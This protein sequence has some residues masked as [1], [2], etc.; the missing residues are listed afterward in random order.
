M[1]ILSR[2]WSQTRHAYIFT[3]IVNISH[4]VNMCIY[5]RYARI[6]MHVTITSSN[7]SVENE[8][9][10]FSLVLSFVSPFTTSL[11]VEFRLRRGIYFVHRVLS[12]IG[13]GVLSTI[14]VKIIQRR[15]LQSFCSSCA[16][17]IKIAAHCH[18]L[19]TRTWTRIH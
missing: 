11:G 7:E 15:C 13:Q 6:Y 19:Q 10:P 1:Y 5:S 18:M 12:P 3:H 17:Q 2:Q 14:S 8:D 16:I 9:F 4:T